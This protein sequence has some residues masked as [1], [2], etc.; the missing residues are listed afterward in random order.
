[1]PQWLV[2]GIEEFACLTTGV[3]E[4]EGLNVDL[5]L[6]PIALNDFKKWVHVLVGSEGG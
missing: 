2:G 5:G 3:V 1:M 4:E 6:W